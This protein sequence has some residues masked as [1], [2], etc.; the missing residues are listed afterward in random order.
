MK[1][2]I[3]S[4]YKIVN[5]NPMKNPDHETMEKWH[6]DPVNWKFGV[7]YYNPEDK[8]IFPPKRFKWMGMTINWAN[9]TSVIFLMLFLALFVVLLLYAPIDKKF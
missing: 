4:K 3:N 6:K 1:L 2:Q 8:R 7:F 5:P 9:T